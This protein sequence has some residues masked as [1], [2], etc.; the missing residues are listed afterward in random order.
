MMLLVIFFVGLAVGY[1]ARR[2]GFCIFGS[3]LELLTLRSGRRIVAVLAAMLVFGLVQMGSYQHGVEY[4]GLL[5]LLGGLLQGVG[6]FLAM[7]CPLSLL[8]RIGE[9]SKFHLLVFVGF[10]AG[11]AV[12]AGALDGPF[13]AVLGPIETRG[14]I[15]LPD[16]FR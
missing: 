10:I 8:V 16:L 9:G 1:I 6:Y 12:Y 14:A 7:G 3:I 15:T 5:F 4:P 13:S 11:V 2:Y